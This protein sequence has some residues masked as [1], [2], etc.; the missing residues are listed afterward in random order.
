MSKRQRRLS[1][2]LDPLR[3]KYFLKL[4]KWAQDTAPLRENSIADLGL[5][6]PQIRRLLG[7]FGQRLAAGGAIACAEDIYW[8][9]AQELDA[10]AALLEKGEA[11][12]E[13]CRRG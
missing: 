7:E 10:L 2:R 5:G 9:E 12:Q 6:H 4:L 1:K 8:L 11:L 3:R 13:L